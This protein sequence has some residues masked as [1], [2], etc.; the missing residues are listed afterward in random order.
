M[1]KKLL[2]KFGI[3]DSQYERPTQK[4]VCGR[5]TDG[6]PC[7]NGPSLKGCCMQPDKPCQPR[8]NAYHR[9][10]RITLGALAI[11]LGLLMLLYQHDGGKTLFNPGDLSSGHAGLLRC[12][13][14]HSGASDSLRGKL[15]HALSLTGSDDSGKCQNCHKIQKRPLLPHNQDLLAATEATI[16]HQNG[17]SLLKLSND[18]F[19]GN[20]TSDLIYCAS[21]HSEHKSSVEDLTV[22]SN[23][24]CQSCHQTQFHSLK[25]GHPEF[26][27]FPYAK[28]T[29]IKFDHVSHF[30][31][32]FSDEDVS[33]YAPLGCKQCHLPDATG[34][35]MET[36]NFEAACSSCHLDQIRG[37]N[38][39]SN[40]GVAMLSIPELDIESLELAGFYTGEWP[41]SGASDLSPLMQLL[42]QSD[43]RYA[44]ITADLGSIDLFDLTTTNY[45]QRKRATELVWLIKELLYDISEGGVAELQSRL[46][47][48][49]GQQLSYQ[50]VGAAISALPEE[51]VLSTFN[52]WLPTL[53]LEVEAFRFGEITLRSNEQMPADEMAQF[54]LVKQELLAKAQQQA[55]AL[56]AQ[57]N[58]DPA[59]EDILGE[60]ILGEDILDE[61]EILTTG[62]EDLIAEDD[63]LLDDDILVEDLDSN[64][65]GNEETEPTMTT[66]DQNPWLANGGWYQDESVI[67]YRPAVHADPFLETWLTLTASVD[68]A[69]SQRVFRS[70]SDKSSV[71]TCIKCHS[72]ETPT[73]VNEQ[74]GEPSALI[75]WHSFKPDAQLNGFTRYSHTS[76]F[77]LMNDKGCSTCHVLNSEAE[78]ME[79]Y[80]D[81]RPE[82]FH[83]NFTPISK[84]TCA[85]CHQEDRAPD[86]CL[87]CH[88]YHIGKIFSPIDSIEDALIPSAE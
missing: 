87:T 44:E 69:I 52:R 10:K 4:W 3:R 83:S 6:R 19:G 24:E 48:G 77:T 25:N 82:D 80:D 51:V 30:N 34:Q 46:Q 86:N 12:E 9:R 29:R 47:A 75:N 31:K 84:E 42:L 81:T 56:A 20:Q 67:R 78:Y 23:D 36:T 17:S 54:E 39:A 5:S 57:N 7:E 66:Q 58:Q 40:N 50:E 2:Q 11:T 85:S 37:V 22:M 33:E 61:G 28:S 27:N 41:K 68:N 72:V 13:T 64:F 38:R 79:S 55:D 70:L 76:H 35:W 16:R 14:C 73:V 74:I 43:P 59:Q 15:G 45:C 8:L 32:H 65:D 60:D 63:I 1:T 88:N 49:L 21:C 53:K 71:G 62:D 26:E 18:I